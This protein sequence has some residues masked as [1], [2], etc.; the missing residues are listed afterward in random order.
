[1]VPRQCQERVLQLAHD[2][3][4]GGHLGIEKTK[5]KILKWYYWPRIFKDVSQH[6]RSCGPCQKTAK[7]SHGE[8]VPLI[9]VLVVG[10]PFHKVTVH[11]VEKLS[12]SR[13]GNAY[14]LVLVDYIDATHYPEAA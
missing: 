9:N 11:M 1:M 4:M 5:D 3:P 14:I 8:K 7:R 6:S 12:R 2:V 13:K 10:V